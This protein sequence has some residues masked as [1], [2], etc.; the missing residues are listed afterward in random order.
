MCPDHGSRTAYGASFR[1]GPERAPSAEIV[2][3]SSTGQY[4]LQRQADAL[5]PLLARVI[6]FPERPKR[7]GAPI[8]RALLLV[9]A[10]DAALWGAVELGRA[11]WRATR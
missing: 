3:D 10:V 6:E 5:A 8:L 2:Q 1:V 11:V 4:R 9:V 7:H